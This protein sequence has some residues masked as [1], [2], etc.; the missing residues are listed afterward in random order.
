M[1]GDIE[2]TGNSVRCG[3]R[4][5]FIILFPLKMVYKEKKN[6]ITHVMIKAKMDLVY[7]GQ[8]LVR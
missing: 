3:D 2:L 7:V 1:E 6:N 8:D 4:L 5:V